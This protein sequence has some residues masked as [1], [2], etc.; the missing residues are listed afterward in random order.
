MIAILTTWT[1]IFGYRDIFAFIGAG[2]REN[3]LLKLS[4]AGE[5]TLL[6]IVRGGA[7][8]SQGLPPVG[9]GIELGVV[10]VRGAVFD[11][12]YSTQPG[13]RNLYN[14]SFLVD[15][16]RYVIRDA[17]VDRLSAA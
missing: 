3:I 5:L 17:R 7:G 14:L 11:R 1:S 13:L 10:E 12:E 15:I 8:F 9:A 2:A 16:R 6:D 4:L